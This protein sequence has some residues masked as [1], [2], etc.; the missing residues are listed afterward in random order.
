MGG[1]W[2]ALDTRVHGELTQ[3]LDQLAQTNIDREDLLDPDQ[4]PIRNKGKKWLMPDCDNCTERCCVH[5]DP[6]SGILLSLR[7]VANLVDSGLGHLIVGGYTFRKS[8][9]GRILDEVDAMPRLAKQPDGNCHFYDPGSGRCQGYGTRPTICR[10]FPYEVDYRKK[11]GKPFTRFIGWSQCPTVEGDEFK[12]SIEQMAR[13]AVVDENVSY[14]DAV[15]LGEHVEA[16]RAAGFGKFLPPPEECPPP[17][18]AVS[19]EG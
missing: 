1:G 13:D 19:A 2:G 15:L 11:N 14:E 5:D 10:R 17:A 18:E 7:D 8:K 3:Q 6:T 4:V 16:L 12:P 9:K